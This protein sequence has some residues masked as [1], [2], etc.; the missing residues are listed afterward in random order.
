MNETEENQRLISRYKMLM[1][2]SPV[3]LTDEESVE[4]LMILKT[5][6]KRGFRL[7][8]GAQDWIGPLA[9]DGR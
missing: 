9:Q 4:L 3:P 8:E 7:A 6:F 1:H 2:P 5:L